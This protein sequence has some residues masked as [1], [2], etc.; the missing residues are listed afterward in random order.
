M[1]RGCLALE[2]P[3]VSAHEFAI[4]TTTSSS[5]HRWKFFRSGGLDQVALETKEDLLDLENLDQKL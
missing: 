2:S 5:V 1:V 4:M 3:G